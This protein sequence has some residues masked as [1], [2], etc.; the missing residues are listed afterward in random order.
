MAKN[1]VVDFAVGDPVEVADPGLAM[2]RQFAPP[3]SK[4]NNHG[5]V[6]EIMENG[7]IMV[8]FPIGND[9]PKEHSQV[10]PYPPEMVKLRA[11]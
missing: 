10:A 11:V 4:P 2:L 6:H 5:V 9:D 1:K 3:G 7:D 8:E